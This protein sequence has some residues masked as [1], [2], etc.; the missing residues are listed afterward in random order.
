MKE[1]DAVV[2][3]GGP[4]GLTAAL[5]LLRSGVTVALCEKLSPGGQVLMTEAIE[6]YPGY[7][8]GIKG[9]ELA[10][11][12]AAH[13]DAYTPER[14]SDEVREMKPD[15]EGGYQ[16]RIGTEWIKGRTVVLCSGSRYRRLGVPGEDAYLGKGVSFCAL[17]DG[18]FFRDQTVAVIGGGNSALEESLYLS[19][20]VKKIYLIHRRDEFRGC[21]CYLDKCMVNP[22]I[23]PVLS[24]VVH[25][26][27][28]GTAGV[29][30]LLL[31]DLKTH[32]KR[33]LVVDGVFVFIGFEPVGDFLPKEL[34]RDPGGFLVTDCEM[35]TNLPGVF[36][37]GDIRSKNCRQVITAAGDGATAATAAY[38][39][40]EK[41]HG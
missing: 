31:E 17:C 9:Y 27:K 4:A 12:F 37:A 19:R 33:E 39:Y 1:F 28:G 21:K 32:E 40:L 5:Y 10:D 7:P 24:T 18:N 38:A 3:G 41:L 2:I 36:A 34:E 22:K 25:E 11:L 20:L 8:K 35:R 16:L 15:P 29:S 13:L 30:S 6:N 14:F 23:E 26:I